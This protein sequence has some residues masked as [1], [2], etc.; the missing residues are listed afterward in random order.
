V[1]AAVIRIRLK[2]KSFVKHPSVN[3]GTFLT[4]HLHRAVLKIN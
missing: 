3:T 4:P 1:V 2:T